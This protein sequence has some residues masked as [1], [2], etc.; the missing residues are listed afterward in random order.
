MAINTG[1]EW[2]I[3]CFGKLWHSK[4]IGFPNRFWMILRSWICWKHHKHMIKCVYGV[5][6]KS[7]KS[8]IFGN[9]LMHILSYLEYLEIPGLMF[10]H[11][12]SRSRSMF[13]YTESLKLPNYTYLVTSEELAALLGC[14]SFFPLD[15][16]GCTSKQ[17]RGRSII[18]GIGSSPST[19]QPFSIKSWNFRECQPW[20]QT[21]VADQFGA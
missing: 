13:G 5:C 17:P 20:I 6:P 3:R 10:G 15:L 4:T 21:K 8:W 7:R 11:V 12:Q 16:I 18:W 19:I 1:T 14:P 2:D 9:S